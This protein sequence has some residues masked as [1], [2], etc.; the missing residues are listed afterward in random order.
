MEVPMRRWVPDWLGV[1]AIFLVILP[2]TMLNGAYTGSMVEVS[3]TL[4][5]NAEDITMGFYAASAGMAV[6]Y[7]IAAKMLAA[8]SAKAL[9]LIDLL[10]QLLL[11][12]ICARTT[13]IDTVI[14]CSFAI[15]F[16]KEWVMLWFIRYAKVLFSKTDQRSE[17]YAYFYPLV[18][19]C[20]QISMVLT[21]QLAYHYNWTSM[22]YFMMILLFVAI[23]CVTMLFRHNRPIKKVPVAELHLREMLLIATGLLMLMY[24]LNYGKLLDW[25]ESSRLCLYLVISPLLIALFIWLQHYSSRPYVSLM[26]LFQPKTLIGYLYM[27]L[28]MFLSTSTTLLSN[29]MN[30]ILK[31]DSTHTY[32]LYVW[33]LPGF[34]A[35]GAICF[36]WFRLQRWRFR[37]LVAGGMGCFA[38]YFGILYFTLS[39]EATYSMLY[40][41]VFFRGLGMMILLIAFSLFATEDLQPKYFISNAF[42]MIVFRSALAPILA[43]SFYSNLLY[44]L[45]QHYFYSLSENITFVDPLAAS[46]YS[47]S[48]G[49]A[50]SQGHGYGEAVQ[51]ATRS[52]YATLQQQSL[53]LAL[54]EMVGYLLIASLVIAVISRFIPFHKTIRVVYAK[55]GDDMV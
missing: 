37:F 14:V 15:G 12:W 31:L 2:V 30:S 28:A 6:S 42:F 13:D 22:Y 16:L 25:M 5:T 8:F 55:T 34:V 39:P 44:R 35:G 46:Q 40:L 32:S 27:I 1:T 53:L 45:T 9:L 4:G 41:P 17:F 54:K 23:L 52:L 3:N 19:G 26:P 38:L 24:V 20:G 11:S 51:V 43:T 29:Y 36:W 18:F 50:L 10:L 49:S 7:P 48:L 33:L 21:A 47:R